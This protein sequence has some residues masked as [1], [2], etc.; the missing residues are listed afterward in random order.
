MSAFR[1]TAA[2]DDG[3]R[4]RGTVEA[5]SVPAAAA[6]LS[7][8]GLWPVAVGPARTAS[9]WMVRRPSS[10]ALAT[11]FEG[12]AALVEAGVPLEQ[13]LRATERT[14]P[15]RVREALERVGR[16]VREGRSLGGALAAED[17]LVPRLTV[18]LVRAGERGVGL[19]PALGQAAVQ[20]ERAA[21][22]EARLRSALTYPM[23]LAVVGSASVAL[24]MFFVVPR[25]AVLLGDLGQAVPAATRVLLAGA[26]LVRRFGLILLVTAVALGAVLVKLIRDRQV[27][28]HAWLLRLPVV[29]PLRH[30]LASARVAR[31]LGAL[32]GTGTPTLAALEIARDAT[33][34]QA[35]AARL[36]A[37]R[38]RVAEG[39]SLSAAL[40]A[41]EAATAV[42]IQL[43][44]IGEASGRLPPLLVKAADLESQVAER[45]VQ[46][47]VTVLEPALIVAFAGV[48]AFVA[49]ALLQAVYAVRPGGV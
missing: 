31:T 20:L 24:I 44:A 46:A 8:R 30:G 23:L 47:L 18:G 17:G 14:A 25:F 10:R 36:V 4:V 2:R 45:R 34:D 48:V 39:A 38:D 13:A 33:G 42:V 41:S 16:R 12:L 19:G 6:L 1:Y 9:G 11:V 35:F 40:A 15:V 21:E 22:L 37:A 28:W 3:A 49:A 26:E 5:E 29:G 27:A 43:T 7:A 32:L